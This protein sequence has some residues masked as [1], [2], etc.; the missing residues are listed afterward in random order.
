MECQ[1]H[2]NRST[3][4]ILCTKKEEVA[5]IKAASQNTIK[6]EVKAFCCI[7]CGEIYE[8]TISDIKKHY[9]Q[10]NLSV[11]KRCPKCRKAKKDNDLLGMTDIKIL[12][13][14]MK[15]REIEKNK[16]FSFTKDHEKRLEGFYTSLDTKTK[17]EIIHNW[18]RIRKLYIS[19]DPTLAAIL[20]HDHKQ[21]EL[22]IRGNN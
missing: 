10:K 9:L 19:M 22:Y 15:T 8:L 4:T 21:L 11:P 16:F 12:I 2:S 18:A 14:L 6:E 1:M 17:N 20:P 7:D 13:D 5:E 3:C